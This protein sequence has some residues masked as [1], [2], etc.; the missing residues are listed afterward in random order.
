M[1]AISNQGNEL[2]REI[3]NV[4]NKMKNEICGM[5]VK[6]RDILKR[7]LDEVKLTQS[8]IRQT[9]HTLREIKESNDVSLTVKYNCK[10]KELSNLPPR[11]RVSLPRSTS[12]PLDGLKLCSFIGKISPLSF[13]T[14]EIVCSRKEP[15]YSV[16]KLL[17]EPCIVATIK[18]S[19]KKLRNVTCHNE[20]EIWTSGETAA[21]KCFNSKGLH[22]KTVQ[23]QS[24]NPTNDISLDKNGNLTYIDRST[25]TLNIVKKGLGE[26]IIRLQ[27]WN[28]S[29]LCTTS[30]GNLLVAM[31]SNDETQ[32]KVVCYSGKREK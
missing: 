18:T 4:V 14:E 6:H 15:T 21:M 12:K 16:Q 22:L 10:I 5:K 1:K 24:G 27:E 9:L 25:R 7:H 29:N 23:N 30:F 8:R 19:Y 11:T 20:D 26:V 2:H 32:S 13:V 3:D 28:P 17:D 31:F